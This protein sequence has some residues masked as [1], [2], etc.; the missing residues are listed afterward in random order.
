MTNF[1]HTYYMLNLYNLIV[2]SYKILYK[3][4]YPYERCG[5]QIYFLLISKF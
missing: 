5:K 1:F 2:F 3:P 4:L